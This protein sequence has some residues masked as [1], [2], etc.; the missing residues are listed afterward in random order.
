M[1]DPKSDHV[2]DEEIR[3]NPNPPLPD[4]GQYDGE[5]GEGIEEPEQHPG[6]GN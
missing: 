5:H 6:V 4:P 3:D 1:S 2:S